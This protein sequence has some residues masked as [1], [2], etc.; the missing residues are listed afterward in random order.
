MTWIVVGSLVLLAAIS[1]CSGGAP[2]ATECAKDP[3][4]C[5][6]HYHDH[7]VT[8]CLSELQDYPFGDDFMWASPDTKLSPF[9]VGSAEA[10]PPVTAGPG[11]KTRT[12]VDY[13]GEVGTG[14][15]VVYGDW[16]PAYIY[17]GFDLRDSDFILGASILKHREEYRDM[18][19]L[20]G[21]QWFSISP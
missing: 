2:N 9:D 14:T 20:R 16:G 6:S 4:A 3:E 1:G 12:R 17:C 10:Y 8:E 11:Y 19:F 7:A 5:L 18:R 13:L 21:I 15:S